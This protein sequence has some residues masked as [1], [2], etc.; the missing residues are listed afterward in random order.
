MFSNMNGSVLLLSLS[1]LVCSC[2][3]LTTEEWQK[4]SIYSVMTDRFASTS[5][6]VHETP[7]SLK[8]YCG[9]TWQGLIE[10]LDYIQGMGFTAVSDQW[11]GGLSFYGSRR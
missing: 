5:E 4:Q 11:K 2:Q 1:W 3:A 6:D 7:C 10:H 8:T 9:G